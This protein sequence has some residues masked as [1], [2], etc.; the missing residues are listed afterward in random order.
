MRHFTIIFF[1][2]TGAEE[3]GLVEVSPRC[4]VVDFLHRQ[5]FANYL[6]PDIFAKKVRQIDLQDGGEEQISWH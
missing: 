1:R 2:T 4:K 3:E 6:K 5:I